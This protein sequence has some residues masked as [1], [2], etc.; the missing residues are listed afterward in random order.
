MSAE[1][2]RG[3]MGARGTSEGGLSASERGGGIC[4]GAR[5][6]ETAGLSSR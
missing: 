6:L 5:R 2:G 3:S 1:G 4:R